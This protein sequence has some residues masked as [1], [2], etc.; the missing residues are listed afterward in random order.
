MMEL[1]RKMK[2]VIQIR[3]HPSHHRRD[4]NKRRVIWIVAL[5]L[6]SI[7]ITE[8]PTYLSYWRPEVMKNEVDWFWLSSFHYKMAEY[9]YWKETACGLAWIIR[10]IAFTKTAVQYSTTVFLASLLILGHM[11]FNLI[12]FWVNYNACA[13][14]YEFMILFIYIVGRSLVRPFKPDAFCKVKSLF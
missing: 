11:I 8:I 4:T 13:W 9:W 10:M 5:L 12:A 14:V 7:E 1:L 2:E 6:I 3:H